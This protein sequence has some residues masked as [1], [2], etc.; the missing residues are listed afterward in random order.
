MTTPIQELFSSPLRSLSL[1]TILFFTISAS[2]VELAQAENFDHASLRALFQPLPK[3][4]ENPNNAHSLEKVALGKK[5]FLDTRF[6]LSKQTSCNSCHNLATYGVDGEAT[7]SGHLG[8]RGTRNS[9]TVLNAALHIS[10]FWDGRAVDV[11]AQALGPVMN[12]VE[13]AM[14]SEM[15]VLNRI[16][17]DQNYVEMFSKAFPGQPDAITFINFGKA[18]GAFERTL[19][20]P[21]PFDDYLNGNDRALSNTELRGLVTFRDS[22]CVACHNGATVGGQMYQKIGL[23]KPYPSKDLGR[24]EVTKSESDKF[25]FKVPSLRNVAKTAPY[26]HDGSVKTLAEAIKLMGAHQLGRDLSAQQIEEIASFL[27]SLTGK[28]PSI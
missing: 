14:P 24:F 9:P 1:F 4:A 10:Q 13:M 28:T 23:I 12:P 15:E 18:I 2:S 20:T 25:V 11:E 6:S 21:S 17:A 22:G 27:N 3:K 16:K 5:L 7:S 26:F 19:L 8:Q